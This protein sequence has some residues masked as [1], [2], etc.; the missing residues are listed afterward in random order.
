MDFDIKEN[1][2]LISCFSDGL[3]VL[4]LTKDSN[5]SIKL[6]SSKG[7]KISRSCISCLWLS[8]EKFVASDKRKTVHLCRIDESTRWIE[9]VKSIS[10]TEIIIKLFTIDTRIH[11]ETISG[12]IVDISKELE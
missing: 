9:T 7:D 3:D 11:G 4:S 2:V 5:G 8:P 10:F 1:K 12:S 6:I